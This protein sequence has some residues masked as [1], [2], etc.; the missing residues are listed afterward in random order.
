VELGICE[1]ERLGQLTKKESR[2]SLEGD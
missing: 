1:S 2:T